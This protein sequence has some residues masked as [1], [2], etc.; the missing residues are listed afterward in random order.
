MDM[1]KLKH[2]VEVPLRGYD[3]ESFVALQKKWWEKFEAVLT[4]THVVT[5]PNGRPTVI[6]V[7]ET[8]YSGTKELKL[9][10]RVEKDSEEQA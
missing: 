2:I 1:P 10:E 8:P 5:A 6:A 7:F 9:E 3:D 4:T